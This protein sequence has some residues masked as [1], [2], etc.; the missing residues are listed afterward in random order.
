[1]AEAE[2]N[3][4]YKCSTID[5]LR[6]QTGK[7]STRLVKSSWNFSENCQE[8]VKMRPYL[9]KK[10]GGGKELSL[11]SECIGGDKFHSLTDKSSQSTEV[12]GRHARQKHDSPFRVIAKIVW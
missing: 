4:E 7:R 10:H 5:S 8:D 6:I 12:Q 11:G 1:M 2:G 9:K 3:A